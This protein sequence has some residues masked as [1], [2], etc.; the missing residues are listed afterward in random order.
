MRNNSIPASL[1]SAALV[2]GT[3]LAWGNVATQPALRGA[4]LTF[5]SIDTEG[6][7]LGVQFP[8]E[9][10]RCYA[11]SAAIDE[12]HNK[13]NVRLTRTSGG[14]DT[15]DAVDAAFSAL[16][17]EALGTA[18]RPVFAQARELAEQTAADLDEM[19]SEA[20]APRGHTLH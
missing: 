8:E 16:L 19:S 9:D 1:L 7:T 15:S 17:N 14:G 6:L 12:G 5:L 4:A 20:G 2:N 10:L 3:C 11:M 13:A 18:L